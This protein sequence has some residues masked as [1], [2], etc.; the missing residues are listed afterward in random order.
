MPIPKADDFYTVQRR[1]WRLT[2]LLTAVLFLFYFAVVGL[3]VLVVSAVSGI[4]RGKFPVLT[5]SSPGRFLVITLILAV[6][7]AVFH[8]LDARLSGAKF[9][10]RRLG[11]QVPDPRDRYHRQF[12]NIVDEIR[13]A[14]GLPRVEGFVLPTLAINCLALSLADKTPAVVVT[15]GLL[16]ESTRDELQ[17]AVAHE[18]A[19]IV[20]GDTFFITLVCSLANVFERV[21]E[22]FESG[23]DVEDRAIAARRPLYAS[24]FLASAAWFSAVVMRLLST[25]ISRQREFLADAAAVELSRAPVS[26]ARIL[27][28]A[29]LKNAFVGDF[30]LT[31]SPLFM[32][33]ADPMSEHEGFWGRLLSTHPPLMSRVERLAG[34]AHKAPAAVIEEVWNL[35][36]NR[37]DHQRVLVSEEEYH[38]N[39]QDSGSPGTF[40]DK[41]WLI[42]DDKKRWIGP[43]TLD[44]L[45][46]NPYFLMSRRVKNLQ[47]RVEARAVEFPAIREAVRRESR[48]KPPSEAGRNLCP[49]CRLPLGDFFYEGVPVKV[50]RKCL[51]KLVETPAMERILARREFTFSPELIMK[52]A[53]FK[54][55]FLTNPIK[56]QKQ[57]DRESPPVFCPSCGYRMVA[58]PYN[59]QFFLPVEKCLSCAKI[60]FDANELELLQI[61]VERP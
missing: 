36:K 23:G 42:Q 1:Q 13:I 28:K 26:L 20:R 58:R 31:Y 6:G 4:V 15:E 49:R 56:A 54:R 38:R 59:Y 19:H 57:K 55:Q 5:P 39:L 34:M 29:H 27:Y 33:S 21:K 32:V 8:F 17:A 9:I 35:Q 44:E 60:W 14:A 53:D 51:G 18:L 43:L 46:L 37:K 40:R 47:E 10:L 45:L 48:K 12:L 41:P 7:L 25:L 30:S 50:C 3:L 61:L 2:L 16:S 24:F 11:G 52:A 22:A